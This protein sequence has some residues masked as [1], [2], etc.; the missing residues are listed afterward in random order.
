[1]ASPKPDLSLL[2]DAVP[3]KVLRAL[4]AASERLGKLGVR[5]A[6]VGGL[7]VGAYGY[8]RN[9]KDVDFLVGEEAFEHHPGGV[10]TMKSGLPIEVEG[11]AIDFLSAKSDEPH[12]ASALKTPAPPE[13]PV[14]PIE[15]LIYLKLK[16]PRQRDFADV[17]ELVKAGL[18]AEAVG[19]YIAQHAPHLA[20]RWGGA[21][22]AARI[23]SDDA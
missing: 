12:V 13:I 14:A 1:M 20:Q 7:A 6:L 11:V 2:E 21:L 9:T 18:D 8:V 4:R 3:P 5:H 23:E 17:V 19:R 16:S 22:A 15:T 10:V